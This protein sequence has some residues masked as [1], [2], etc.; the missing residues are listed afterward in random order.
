MKVKRIPTLILGAMVLI[1]ANSFC[2]HPGKA[3]CT[4]TRS[5]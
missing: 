5:H 2:R 4:L 1:P 3:P